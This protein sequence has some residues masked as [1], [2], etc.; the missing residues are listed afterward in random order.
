MQIATYIVAQSDKKIMEEQL[1]SEYDKRIVYLIGKV[2]ND[3]IAV[4][5]SKTLSKHSSAKYPKYEDIFPDVEKEEIEKGV[6]FESDKGIVVN[7]EN[8]FEYLI[9]KQKYFDEKKKNK[10]S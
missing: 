9:E 5:L 2:T 6:Y 7:K 3:F 1:K 10:N 4:S 8:A